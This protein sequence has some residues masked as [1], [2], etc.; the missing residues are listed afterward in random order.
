MHPRDMR[1]ID[2]GF[3]NQMPVVLV[4]PEVILV[5]LGHIRALIKADLVILFDSP[6]TKDRIEDSPFVKDLQGKLRMST[7]DARGQPF[8]FR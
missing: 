2:G 1:K 5:N 4:R 8:E 3:S 7:S 6:D